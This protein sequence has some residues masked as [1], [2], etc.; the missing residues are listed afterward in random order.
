MHVT[1]P[2][3]HLIIGG[4][5]AARLVELYNWQTGQI[6][7]LNDLP[8]DMDAS[9]GTVLDGIPILCGTWQSGQGDKNCIKLN[10]DDLTWDRVSAR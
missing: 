7:Q 6:C 2:S 8:Y 1:E 3:W 9:S 5:Y 10:K 4:S